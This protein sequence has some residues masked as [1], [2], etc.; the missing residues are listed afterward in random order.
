MDSVDFAF[1]DYVKFILAL[2]F[3]LALIVVGAVLARRFGYG[4]PI[5]PKGAIKR[6]AIVEA[7]NIDPKRRM[8]LV[9]RDGIEH[10]LLLG[11]NQ[12]LLIESAIT[13]PEN[14]FSRALN[15]AAAATGGGARELPASLRNT[16]GEDTP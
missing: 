11:A 14:P 4:T 5:I 12:D 6:L 10:L 7:M 9:R 15:E 3:V 16:S 1:V 2:V 8:I 13:P